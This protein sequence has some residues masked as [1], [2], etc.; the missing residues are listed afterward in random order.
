MILIDTHAHLDFPELRP[1]ITDILNDAKKYK[2]E[3][4]EGKNPWSIK[5]DIAL[6]C[7]TQNELDGDDPNNLPDDSNNDGVPDYLD[8]NT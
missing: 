8:K 4:F 2:V 6:P 3:Y 5:C 1:R 7:A